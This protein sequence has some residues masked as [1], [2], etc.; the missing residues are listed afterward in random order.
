MSLESC[1]QKLD[2]LTTYL[3]LLINEQAEKIIKDFL[4]YNS[5][6]L[7]EDYLKSKG[8]IRNTSFWAK[9]FVFVTLNGDETLTSI[10]IQHDIPGAIPITIKQ[11]LITAIDITTKYFERI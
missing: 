2:D 11:S 3:H 6:K 10:T 5:R 7:I 4:N 1:Y 8:Y 9:G